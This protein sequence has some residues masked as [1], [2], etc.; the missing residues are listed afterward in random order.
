M[1]PELVSVCTHVR[2]RPPL[3]YF[4][5]PKEFPE[6]EVHVKATV[7]RYGF[8]LMSYSNGVKEGLAGAAYADSQR[9][10]AQESTCMNR[11]CTRALAR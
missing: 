10:H 9:T 1:N 5:D 7:D 8:E 6:V 11:A 2:D 4:E 3:V